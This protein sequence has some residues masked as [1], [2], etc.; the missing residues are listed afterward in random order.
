MAVCRFCIFFRIIF[1]FHLF[2]PVMRTAFTF[3]TSV[4]LLLQAPAQ[5]IN[6]IW[7]GSLVMEAGGCFPVYNIELQIQVTGNKIKGVSYHFSDTANY[8]K[9][10]FEGTYSADSN[11]ISITEVGV[12][13]FHIPADCIPCIKKYSLSFHK[14]DN[15]EQIRGS[16]AGTTMDGKSNC[17]PGTIVLN[18]VVKSAFKPNLPKTFTERKNELVREI[19]VDTGT[20]KIDFYDNGQIDGDTISVYVNELP[21]VSN[22]LLGVKPISVTIKIDLK[23]TI[24]EVVMVGEN[25][26]TIPPNTALMIINANDKRYQLY[27]ASDEKKNAMVRFIYEK[28]GTAVKTP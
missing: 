1:T 10:N 15:V 5:N 9:E 14:K 11:L 2:S 13:T 20:I 12:T 23:K 4:L 8:V 25:M 19:R 24:Q 28:S 7:K 16:W 18:R 6:G 17:P 27:L 26:G 3:L 21:V 22:R